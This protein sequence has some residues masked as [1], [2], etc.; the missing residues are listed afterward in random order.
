[1]DLKVSIIMDVTKNIQSLEEILI[2]LFGRKNYFFEYFIL[3]FFYIK[4]NK[5]K[6]Y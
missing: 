2:F 6:G 3:G 4:Q 5:K 1:M